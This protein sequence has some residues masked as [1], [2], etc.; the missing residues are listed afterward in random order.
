MR[1]DFSAPPR[2]P[3][4]VGA[5]SLLAL[6]LALPAVVPSPAMADADPDASS[7]I[8]LTT[9]AL[10]PLATAGAGVPAAAYENLRVALESSEEFLACV[11]ADEARLDRHADL[12]GLRERIW[13]RGGTE[14]D[15]ATFADLSRTTAAAQAAFDHSLA[16]LRE[17]AH[18]RLA[19]A[20]GE[21]AAALAMRVH[22]NL[23]HH[24]PLAALCLD[25]TEQ[26]WSALEAAL[27]KRGSGATLTQDEQAAAAIYDSSSEVALVAARLAASK[28][29]YD[30]YMADLA[31]QIRTAE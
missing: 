28:A 29:D 8:A 31:A 18:S 16:D 12:A 21:N 9:R 26:Q 14:Q 4:V 23:G 10:T 19:A 30:A 5:M 2:V 1:I 27:A 20:A 11:G 7:R 22:A 17:A 6:G 25:L 24:V 15:A 13:R 3:T